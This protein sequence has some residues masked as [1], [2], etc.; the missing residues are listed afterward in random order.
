M[1]VNDMKKLVLFDL[2]G[3]LMDTSRGIIKSIEY[4]LNEMRLD[5]SSDLR[6]YIGPPV[7]YSFKTYA[8]LDDENAKKA[9]AIFRRVYTEIFL[10]EAE[11]YPG[12]E[13]LLCMLH[14]H[15][16]KCGIATFK[17]ESYTLKLLDHFGLIGKL[18]VIHGSD[19]LGEL[20]KTDIIRLCMNE[21][22]CAESETIMIGDTVHDASAAQK[23]QVDFVAVTYGF[24]FK[25]ESD[26]EEY[27]CVKICGTPKKLSGYLTNLK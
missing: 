2:D 17:R 11:I 7:E 3:T 22:N 13:D 4:V 25:I 20:T 1:S 16:I 10:Y 18:D 8:G 27:S 12:I 14:C 9:A 6:K 24:G 15:N 5:N 23:A 21:M 26:T 19:E